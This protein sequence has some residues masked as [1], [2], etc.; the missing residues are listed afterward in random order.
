M[1]PNPIPV[2]AQQFVR[3]RRSNVYTRQ[4]VKYYQCVYNK[5]RV[6]PGMRIVPFGY[7]GEDLPE[8]M[9]MHS[10]DDDDDHDN[11]DEDSDF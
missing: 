4:T 9:V 2:D 3:D 8:Q 11:D 10:D 5:G 1:P 6:L 7:Q